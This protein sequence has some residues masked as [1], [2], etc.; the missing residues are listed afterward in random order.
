M[1]WKRFWRRRHRD[2]DFEQEIISYLEHEIDR[3]LALGMT[4]ADARSAA[5]R[6]FGNVTTFKERVH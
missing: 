6:K 1:S 5:R 4:E 3:N 2:A